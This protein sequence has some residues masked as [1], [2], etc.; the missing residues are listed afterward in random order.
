MP[1]LKE[2]VSW[3]TYAE[4]YDMLLA[5]NP[6]YQALHQEVLQRTEEW[7]IYTND[8]ILDLGGGTGNY[9]CSLAE[10]YPHAKIIHL[11]RDEGMN[12][13]VE[14]KQSARELQ[15][16]HI[17]T[18]SAESAHFE[19]NSIK[20]C[21]S[22]HALYTLPN[23]QLILQRLYDWLEPNGYGLFVDPGRRVKVLDWQIAIGSRMIRQ[24]GWRKTWQ[25]MWEGK[26][27]S[28]QNRKI[29]QMQADGTYWMHS[30][31]EFCDVIKKAG[32]TIQDSGLTFRKISDWASVRKYPAF[33]LKKEVNASASEQRIN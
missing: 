30:H 11:D 32:F 2:R 17:V 22:I 27:V 24:Y 13:V 8:I 16:L 19:K 1:Q 31:A 18:S 33:S 21:I 4:Q 15:N 10:K 28:R 12:A 6:F 20:A 9:S 7:N 3:S 14:K 26:E 5:Y 25:I 29:S 23:P